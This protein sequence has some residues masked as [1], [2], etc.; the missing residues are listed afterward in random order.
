MTTDLN[1]IALMAQGLIYK[2]FGCYCVLNPAACYLWVCPQ[3]L[4]AKVV[5]Q[6]Q[7]RYSQRPPTSGD[8]ESLYWFRFLTHHMAKA[9]LTKVTHTHTHPWT[10]AKTHT[11]KGT[12]GEKC[13]YVRVSVP[14]S[15]ILS[16]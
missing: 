5:H 8:T 9:N 15:L 7:K 13:V 11:R 4:H 12:E 6:Y 14:P 10:N 1:C 2:L 3:A 16:R